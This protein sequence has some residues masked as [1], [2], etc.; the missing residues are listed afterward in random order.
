[1]PLPEPVTPT[2]EQENS[3]NEN[4][5]FHQ[6]T[7]YCS[8]SPLPYG[9]SGVLKSDSPLTPGICTPF[10]VDFF[11]KDC[12]LDCLLFCSATRL[13][14]SSSFKA[15]FSLFSAACLARFEG[16]PLPDAAALS[17]AAPS[18]SFPPPL[19][20]NDR[21]FESVMALTS[22]LRRTS[23]DLSTSKMTVYTGSSVVPAT[24]A[25]IAG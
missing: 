18:L 7:K 23:V 16:P 2:S 22:A 6:K 20:W 13:L 3:V 11:A 8:I 14:R 24:L 12:Q 5:Y 25:T 4:V 9:L 15:F 17:E 21:F 19:N 1:M 10:F